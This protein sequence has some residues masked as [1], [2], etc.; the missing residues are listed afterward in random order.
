MIL[1]LA[2]LLCLQADVKTELTRSIMDAIALADLYPKGRQMMADEEYLI[3]LRD[4]LNLSNI[5][6]DMEQTG[7]VPYPSRTQFFNV[8][9]RLAR[10]RDLQAKS[11]KPAAS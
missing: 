10:K 8:Y 6:D 7:W 4:L 3:V 9:T 11:S 2:H 5:L 1:M